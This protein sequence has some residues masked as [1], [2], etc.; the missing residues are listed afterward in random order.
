MRKLRLLLI[1]VLAAAWTPLSLH[2][3]EAPASIVVLNGKVHTMDDASSTVEAVA[4]REGRFVYVG[5]NHGAREFIGN[6]TRVLDAKGKSVVPGF[7]ETHTHAIGVARGEA[8]QHFRQL[9]SMAEIREWVAAKALTTKPGEWIWIPRVDLTRFKEGRFPTREELDQMQPNRPLVFDWMYAG[10]NQVQILN[11]PALAAAKITRD[12]KDP[13]DGKIVRDAQGNPTGMIRNARKLI[14]P[15]LPPPPKL[16]EARLMTE[17][18]RVHSFYNTVGITSIDDR[19]TDVETFRLYRKMK[20][21][22]RLK[23]RA[24]ITLGVGYAGIGNAIREIQ[25]LPVKPREGDDWV[26]IGSLKLRIDGGL[27]YG[28]AYLREPYLAEGSERYYDLPAGRGELMTPADQVREIIRAGHKAG[29]QMSSH[30]AG[31]AGVDVVLD[32]L[33]A[34]DKDSPIAP[35]RYNLIHAYLPNP[36]TV[37][38]AKKLGVVVDTQPMWYYKDGDALVT[39]IGPERASHMIGLR[40]WLNGGVKVAIN[41]DHMQGVDP[42]KALN[43]YN[44]LLAMYVAISR[45]TESGKIHGPEQKV[46]RMEA[47]RMTTIDAAYM[48]FDEKVK[49]SIEIGKLGDLAVLSE[50]FMNCPEEK[51]KDIQVMATVLDGKVIYEPGK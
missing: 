44:P 31:D 26:R 24:Q 5:N 39:T 29:F 23:V 37:A 51:I 40:D 17:L 46:S 38:R 20:D 30:V 2:A 16:D 8:A 13:E 50:D 25:N 4:I 49:G 48:I 19:R 32:A 45:K 47:L 28:T 43:P 15:F 9:S 34:A 27:L 6:G 14:V 18:E 1:A 11:T 41:A 22:G 7:I 3:A 36:D 42:N 33:E 12:T 10:I 21:E 35:M